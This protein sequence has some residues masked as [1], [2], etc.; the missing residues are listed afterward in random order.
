MKLQDFEYD[1][2]GNLIHYDGNPNLKRPRVQLG[3]TK[4]HVEEYVKCANSWKYFAEHYYHILDLQK[5]MIVPK[6]RDYQEK[7]IDS[8]IDNRFTNILASRQC[9]TKDTIISIRNKETGEISKISMFELENL[10]ED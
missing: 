3:Y 4:E 10:L 5:G 8:F 6:I 7:M 1:I 9:V 2:N